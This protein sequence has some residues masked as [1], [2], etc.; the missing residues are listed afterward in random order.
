MNLTYFT[1]R[2]LADELRT[3]LQGRRI[4]KAWVWQATDLVLHVEG[5]GASPAF[6]LTA[7]GPGR[8]AEGASKRTI[9]FFGMD[10]AIYLKG[11]DRHDSSGPDGQDYRIRPREARPSGRDDSLSS[12]RRDDGKGCKRDSGRRAG[13]SHLGV[14]PPRDLPHESHAGNLAGETLSAASP[15]SQEAPG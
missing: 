3:S 4:S 2:R 8:A 12:R 15:V 6:R 13:G 10:E 14:C 1:L 7:V 5:C 9:C 11:L